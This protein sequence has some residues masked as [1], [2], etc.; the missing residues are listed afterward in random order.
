MSWPQIPLEDTFGDCLRKAM[1]GNHIDAAALAQRTGIDAHDIT[2]WTKDRGVASA[3]QARALAPVLRLDPERFAVRAADTWAP[4][5]IERPDVS[6][7]EQDSAVISNGYVFF[8][9]NGDAA[10][11]DPA[12]TPAKLLRV[13][14]DGGYRLRY[15]IATHKHNDHCDALAAVAREYP[16]AQIVMHPVDAP[17]IGA[18]ASK[19][20]PV[21]DGEK[22]PFGDTSIQMFHTPGHTD[23]SSS[24]LFNSTL[25]TGDMLFAGSVGGAYADTATYDDILNRIRTKMFALADDTVIMPGHGPPSTIGL[26]KAHN[27]FFPQV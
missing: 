22:L 17:A 24:F 1:I 3:D 25:F 10:L 27:P 21:R 9:E 16:E 23:G 11:V 20:L 6:R 8:L 7:H 14:R 5:A 2:N 13:L 19:V 15:I 4:P 18:L 26:E 12:G